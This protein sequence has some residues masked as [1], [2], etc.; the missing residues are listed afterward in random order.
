MLKKEDRDQLNPFG[1]PVW[2]WWTRFAA[3]KPTAVATLH[4]SVA[5]SRLSSPTGVNTDY[6]IYRLIKTEG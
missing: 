6:Q 5:K 4:R 1:A 3:A 2:W